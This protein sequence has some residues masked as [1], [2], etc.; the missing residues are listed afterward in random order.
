MIDHTPVYFLS[1]ANEKTEEGMK[2][3]KAQRDETQAQQGE[4]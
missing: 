2:Q 4:Q 1:A 3:K